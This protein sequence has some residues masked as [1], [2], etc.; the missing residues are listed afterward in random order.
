MQVLAE[1]I[2]ALITVIQSFAFFP[3]KHLHGIISFS[4]QFT[5]A[6]HGVM[7]A[8]LFAASS[9]MWPRNILQATEYCEESWRN[10]AR[11]CTQSKSSNSI[12]RYLGFHYLAEMFER[13]FDGAHLCLMVALLYERGKSG[14]HCTCYA[15]SAQQW[16]LFCWKYFFMVKRNLTLSPPTGCFFFLKHV[17]HPRR[18]Q[19]NIVR[20]HHILIEHTQKWF[21]LL[22]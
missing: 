18:H 11:C 1:R 12:G 22:L 16:L 7:R 17:F 14:C 4:C 9:H 2:T 19:E 5:N 21:S 15:Y 3:L 8:F 10:P 20:L 13:P 6:Y